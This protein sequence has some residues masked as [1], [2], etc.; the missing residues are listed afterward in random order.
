MGVYLWVEGHG[1][2]ISF[3][4]ICIFQFSTMSIYIFITIKLGEKRVC[5]WLGN[6]GEGSSGGEE[7][8]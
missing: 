5:V 2:S 1:I 4:L 7:N 6:G 3:L 8:S